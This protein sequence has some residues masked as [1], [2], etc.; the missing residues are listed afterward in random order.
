MPAM[1]EWML[2][3]A[4]N[5]IQIGGFILA[6]SSLVRFMLVFKAHTEVAD[7]LKALADLFMTGGAYTLGAGAHHSDGT[8][9]QKKSEIDET[10]REVKE[11]QNQ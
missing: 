11:F 7:T 4:A 10:R 8:W 1:P 3:F 6:L 5:R 9:E 2:W